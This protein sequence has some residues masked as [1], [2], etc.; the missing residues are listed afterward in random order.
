MIDAESPSSLIF[1]PREGDAGVGGGAGTI[2]DPPKGEA[3]KYN[4]LVVDDSPLNRKMLIKLL[5][6]KG[7]MCDEAADGLQA[8]QKVKS[9]TPVG[10]TPGTS[11]RP[12]AHP[13]FHKVLSTKRFGMGSVAST[14]G[15]SCDGKSDG[16]ISIHGDAHATALAQVLGDK[17][18]QSGHGPSAG[19]RSS[20]SAMVQ[21][22]PTVGVQSAVPK[23]YDA[24]LIDF[25]MPVCDG[26]TAT[27]VP[28]RPLPLA[29]LSSCSSVCYIP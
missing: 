20:A 10:D 21:S 29:L 9:R 4:L 22:L 27:K 19:F 8:I 13:S 3:P 16:G 25:V 14:E 15:K 2:A 6:A 23:M 5:R 7:H 26:P 17:L 1:I 24:I 11:A 28:L 18:S 12:S